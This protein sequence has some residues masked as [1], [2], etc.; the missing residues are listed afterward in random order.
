MH[1]ESY[2]FYL[3][4]VRVAIM[5]RETVKFQQRVFST[6]YQGAYPNIW[7]MLVLFV[8]FAIIVVFALV[9]R[10]MGSPYHLGD[11]FLFIWNLGV[12]LI[13]RC[14]RFCVCLWQWAFH[15]FHFCIWYMGC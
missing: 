3:H 10:Q 15:F 9:A 11:L 13:M 12:C 5:C 7:D 6:S 8:V 2:R 4:N 14:T 1:I